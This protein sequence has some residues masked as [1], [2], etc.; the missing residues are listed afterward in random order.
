MLAGMSANG[1][2]RF[3]KTAPLG[4]L[5]GLVGI[6]GYV[7]TSLGGG[8]PSGWGWLAWAS[9]PSVALAFVVLALSKQ[10]RRSLIGASGLVALSAQQLLLG[11]GLFSMIAGWQ[12]WRWGSLKGFN[13]LSMLLVLAG[14]LVAWSRTGTDEATNA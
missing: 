9:W 2:T 10:K 8:T 12:V 11:L 4:G 14:G 5:M 7:A 13:I 6:I 3:I 1:R